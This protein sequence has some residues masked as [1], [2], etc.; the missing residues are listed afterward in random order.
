MST[1]PSLES[2]PRHTVLTAVRAV[3][4]VFTT[5]AVLATALVGTATSATAASP[6]SSGSTNQAFVYGGERHLFEIDPAGRLAH[7]WSAPA[8]ATS[9]SEIWAGRPVTGKPIAY[10]H[11]D[12]QHVFARTPNNNLMHWVLKAGAQPRGE[13]VDTF[14]HVRSDPT[15]FS[16]G[17]RRHVFYATNGSLEHRSWDDSG[18]ST[19]DTWAGPAIT[20]NPAALVHNGEQHIFARA[21]DN[22][23]VH[24]VWYD[25]IANNLPAVD[26]FGTGPAALSSD[27]VGFGYDDQVHV[28]VRSGGGGVQHYYRDASDGRITAVGWAGPDVVGSLLAYTV[29][30]RQHLFGRTATGGIVH[31]VWYPS[32]PGNWPATDEWSPTGTVA[33][34]SDPAGFA[35]DDQQQVFFRRPDG[36]LENRYWDDSDQSLHAETWAG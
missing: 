29:G 24:W 32:I 20:G 31:W 33:T 26:D 8:P 13:Y 4:A 25:G 2:R 28:F 22:R 10:V 21:V 1:T 36:R 30:D 11:N 35:I 34:A 16:F 5:T 17:S 3:T 12:E 19:K 27:P 7:S 23:L 6:S 15:G 18:K 9:R 14:N